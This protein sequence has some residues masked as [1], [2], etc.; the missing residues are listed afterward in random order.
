MLA[1]EL[2]QS[3]VGDGRAAVSSATAGD[4]RVA[5][6]SVAAAGGV[7]LGQSV[8]ALSPPPSSVE[9]VAV[10]CGCCAIPVV[11]T[12]VITVL[13]SASDAGEVGGRGR[14][15]QRVTF[16]RLGSFLTFLG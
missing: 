4:D 2:G 5:G 10:A 7:M 15:H 1:R 16:L 3:G 9:L 6:S 12:V 8:S 13:A 11:I 14:V